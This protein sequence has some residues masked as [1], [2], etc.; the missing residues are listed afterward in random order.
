MATTKAAPHRIPNGTNIRLGD[1]VGIVVDQRGPTVLM[2]LPG[3]KVA[4]VPRDQIDRVRGR[5][6]IFGGLN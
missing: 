4:E 5:Y 1:W 2:T 3:R 6:V